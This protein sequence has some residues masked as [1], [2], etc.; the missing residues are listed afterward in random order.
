MK[1]V[2]MV[3]GVLMA[4]AALSVGCAPKVAA[5]AATPNVAVPA[6][7]HNVTGTVTSLNSTSITIKTTT[8]TQTF[9]LT[10]NTTYE[11]QN[12]S[13]DL[14]QAG[15]AVSKGNVTYNCTVIYTG[16]EGYPQMG[17]AVYLVAK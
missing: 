7:T 15:Q 9:P 14:A 10:D 5:P 3:T 6:A 17:V 4:M 8:G 12:Q 1:I 16:D 2:F 11:L 13:C